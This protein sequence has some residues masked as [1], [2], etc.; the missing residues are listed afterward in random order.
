MWLWWNLGGQCIS[1][2]TDWSK[3]GVLILQIK[4]RWN[5][6][7]W[8]SW[9]GTMSV[10]KRQHFYY[11]YE[12][13]LNLRQCFIRYLHTLYI[14]LCWNLPYPKLLLN[15]A[16]VGLWVQAVHV[17]VDGAKLTGRYSRV[18]TETCLQNGIMNKDILLLQKTASSLRIYQTSRTRDNEKHLQKYNRF[19][20]FLPA[21]APEI[22][23][24]LFL[25]I[26]LK[27]FNDL[28]TTFPWLFFTPRQ[29]LWLIFVIVYVQRLHYI[30]LHY[31]WYTAD[32]I[33]L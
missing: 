17:V 32:L 1:Y 2:S 25:C 19:C 29:F 5:I 20:I 31:F 9:R 3:E 4:V 26:L 18:A 8:L 10:I 23:E 14:L 16:R 21:A 27:E 24:P 11:C 22:N 28:S 13:I 6:F 15:G 33:L 12:L 7:Y 30:F